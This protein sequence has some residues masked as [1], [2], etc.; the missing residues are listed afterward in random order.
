MIIKNVFNKQIQPRHE[1]LS[2]KRRTL[3]GGAMATLLGSSQRVVADVEGT[4]GDPFIVHGI[5]EPVEGRP[6]TSV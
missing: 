5:Y 3:I 4:S 6:A 1:P 2:L